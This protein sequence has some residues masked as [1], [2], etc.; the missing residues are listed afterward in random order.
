MATHIQE[1]IMEICLLLSLH[2]D[3]AGVKAKQ[4]FT[5]VRD[6][7]YTVDP[8]DIK[9]GWPIRQDRPDNGINCAQRSPRASSSVTS[10]PVQRALHPIQSS[11]TRFR[12]A[13]Q[14]LT[15]LGALQTASLIQD[16]QLFKQ[17]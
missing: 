9:R 17:L 4:E 12:L 15:I 11:E 8:G 1:E 3:G 14:S 10:S 7:E 2:A 6:N 13:Q 5:S 16:K